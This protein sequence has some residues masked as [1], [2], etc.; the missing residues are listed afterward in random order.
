MAAAIVDNNIPFAAADTFSPLFKDMFRDSEI[1]KSFASARTKTH[2]V[3]RALKP[4][5]RYMFTSQHANDYC[6]HFF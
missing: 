6:L 3:H 4:Y 1:A 2:I 5:F